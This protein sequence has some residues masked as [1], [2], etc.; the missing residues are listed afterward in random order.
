M[1]ARASMS[2]RTRARRFRDKLS[3]CK[4]RFLCFL[5][6]RDGVE[7]PIRQRKN[8]R[9]DFHVVNHL[10][11]IATRG[12]FGRYQSDRMVWENFSVMVSSAPFG[13]DRSCGRNAAEQSGRC[14]CVALF[15][16]EIGHINGLPFSTVER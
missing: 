4:R 14:E 9:G 5:K 1:I 6:Q 8:L 13:R 16:R 12:R 7:Q 10:G 15:G 2:P 3:H 11:P